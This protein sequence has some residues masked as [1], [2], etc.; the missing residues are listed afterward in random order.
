MFNSTRGGGHW[1]SR[2]TALTYTSGLID[3]SLS[4]RNTPGVVPVKLPK[5]SAD[6]H[7]KNAWLAVRASGAGTM[8]VVSRRTEKTRHIIV[9]ANS[10]AVQ[11]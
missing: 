8:A 2:R 4:A 5:G 10:E 9:L 7:S 6:E 1:A 3:T 11:L